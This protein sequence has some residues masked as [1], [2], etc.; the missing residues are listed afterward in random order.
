MLPPPSSEGLR[1]VSYIK[2]FIYPRMN[3]NEHKLKDRLNREL[4]DLRIFRIYKNKIF[5]RDIQDKQD[6]KRIFNHGNLAIL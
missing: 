6:K 2:D 1:G 4:P 3:T 5:N